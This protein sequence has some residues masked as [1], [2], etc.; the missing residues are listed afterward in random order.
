M[1]QIGFLLILLSLTQACSTGNGLGYRGNPLIGWIETKFTENKVDVFSTFRRYPNLRSERFEFPVGGRYGEGY[2]IAQKFGAENFKFGQRL[3]LGE[4]WNYIA[5]GD[6]DFGAPV[7][8][9]SNGVVSSVA[10]HGGGWGRVVRIVHKETD[11][12]SEGKG[13]RFIESLYAHLWTIDVIPGQIVQTGEW[14]GTIGN[15]GGAYISHLHFELR[16]KPNL[17]LGGGY[18]YELDGFLP[19]TQF[20][21]KKLQPEKRIN[22]DIFLLNAPNEG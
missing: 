2:Y 16:D 7:F 17:P 9:I 12:K 15:A 22:E 6:S 10:D 19:P 13:F 8:S 3:H 4:D 14:I 1:Y 5:G 18:S 20:L 21:S 11:S